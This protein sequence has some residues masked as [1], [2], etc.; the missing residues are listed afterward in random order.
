MYTPPMRGRQA[1]LSPEITPEDISALDMR[2]FAACGL[3]NFAAPTD[4]A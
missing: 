3:H 1:I 4:I 2:G